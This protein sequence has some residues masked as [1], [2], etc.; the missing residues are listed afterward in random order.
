[1]KIESALNGK[2]ATS[3][4]LIEITQ[5]EPKTIRGKLRKWVAEGKVICM[6]P[7]GRIDHRNNPFIYTL[8]TGRKQ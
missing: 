7:E 6:N 3:F 4:E 8:A 5:M 2:T 1:M